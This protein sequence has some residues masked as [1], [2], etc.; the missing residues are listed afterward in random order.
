MKIFFPLLVAGSVI[1]GSSFSAA[2]AADF[3]ISFEWGDLK[4][5]TNGNPNR[6]TNPLFNLSGVPAGT[7]VIN[8]Q[9]KDLNVPSFYHGGGKVQY[10]GGSSVK[11]GAFRYL[12]PCPPGGRHMYQWTATALDSKG[13]KLGEAKAKKQYP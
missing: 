5:C 9:M 12:S 3:A 7:A 1:A 11:P 4:K 10:T 6:V 13:K 2:Q 8:F